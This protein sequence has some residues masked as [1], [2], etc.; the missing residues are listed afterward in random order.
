MSDKIK[1]LT[2][3]TGFAKTDWI[4]L[5]QTSD[6][7]LIFKPAIHSGGVR[8]ILVRFKKERDKKWEQLDGQDFRK[9]KLYEG[10]EIELGTEQTKIFCEEIQK[11][12]KIAEQGVVSGYQEY[13]VAPSDRVIVIDDANK[14]QVLQQILDNNYSEEFW[15][16]LKENAPELAKKI[17]LNHLHETR[18][19]A[20]EEFRTSL[21]IKGVGE[22][23]YWQDFFERNRW[24]FGYGLNYQ[25]LKQE[26][27]Q[28]HYGG[29]RVDGTGG[30]RGDTLCTAEGDIKFTV[31]VEIKT[32]ATPIIQGASAQRNGAWSVAKELTDGITQLQANL[33]TWEITGSRTDDN[34]DR[35]EEN[36]AYTVI[37]K[38]I[39]LIGKLSQIAA[40]RDQR[41]S[42]ERFRQGIHA[43]EILTFDELFKRAEFILG[44]RE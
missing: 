31:L 16:L 20:L 25:I 12:R 6:T 32:P 39:L 27:S 18:L 38:G 23:A 5:K 33:S 26:Q 24:I 35:F 1:T 28:P 41:N 9:L 10:V 8:G 19:E 2:V 17:L 44:E 36:E 43:V 15:S 42:F 11:R 30:Q 3:T 21:P 13:V 7:V 37:P 22:E 34:R 14:R 29:T 40:D 4:V